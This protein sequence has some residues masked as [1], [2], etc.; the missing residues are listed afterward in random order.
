VV[1]DVVE[2]EQQFLSHLLVNHS[3]C[4]NCAVLCGGRQE[5]AKVRARQMQRYVCQ[6]YRISSVVTSQS[7]QVC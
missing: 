3:D 1:A 7:K 5:V 6:L 2:L 4:Q